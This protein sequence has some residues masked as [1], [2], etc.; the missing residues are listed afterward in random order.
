MDLYRKGSEITVD[1]DKQEDVMGLWAV[2]TN[3][4]A[5][6]PPEVFQK[7]QQIYAWF[8]E[9]VLQ[10]ASNHPVE[11]QTPFRKKRR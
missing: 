1:L 8:Y 9:Q 2:M 10:L 4:Q 5:S 6:V 3:N 7:G 11:V